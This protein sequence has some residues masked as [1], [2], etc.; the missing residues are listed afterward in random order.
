MLYFPF[1]NTGY[2]LA[3]EIWVYDKKKIDLVMSYGYNLEVVWGKKL[4]YNNE[5]IISI[6]NKYD[7][8]NKFAPEWSSKDTSI[9]TPI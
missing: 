4:K 5:K 6:I 2:L 7:T 3:K 1:D 8:K 9:S